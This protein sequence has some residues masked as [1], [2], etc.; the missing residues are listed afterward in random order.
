MTNSNID[1]KKK[2]L[3]QNGIKMKYFKRIV[4]K[5]KWDRIP[6]ERIREIVHKE[7]IIGK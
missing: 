6:N 3:E 7:L 1:G 2:P 4:E 5:I